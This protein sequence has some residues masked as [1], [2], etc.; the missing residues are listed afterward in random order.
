MPA[1]VA[2]ETTV[3]DVNE[4]TDPQ[5]FRGRVNAY[6]EGTFTG[7]VRVQRRFTKGDAT[8]SA[9]MNFLDFSSAPALQT[10]VEHEDGVEYRIGSDASAFSGTGVYV[11]LSQ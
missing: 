4:W 1:A 11:R 3:S 8:Q 5:A 7:H 10:F 2:L 9:W 6:V